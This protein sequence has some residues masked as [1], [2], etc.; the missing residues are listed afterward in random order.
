M[1]IA[2]LGATSQI[3]Q[4]LVR[5]FASQSEH[6]LTLYARRPEVVQN[7]LAQAGFAGRYATHSF[8]IFG[9]A[10]HFDAIL[11][12]VGAGDPSRVLAMQ[13]SVFDVT[14]KYDDMVL[15][16]IRS[17][18]GCR[19]IFL[20]SGAVYGEQFT[21]P[22]VAST[23]AVVPVNNL[24][25]QNWYGVV[26]LYAECR[27]R[28]LAPIPIV[29]I[30]VFNYFSPFYG[31]DKPFLITDILRAI[32]DGMVMKT[33]SEYIVRDYIHSSDLYRLVNAILIA[34][35]MNAA[36]DV[37]SKAPVDKPTLLAR[38]KEEFG[39]KYEITDDCVGVNATGIKHHYYSE[40]TY[41]PWLS[42]QPEFTSLEGILKDSK[43][44]LFIKNL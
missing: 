38:M 13:S 2:I 16:Y 11:N 42:Y 31:L 35:P 18:S 32:R 3:A 1:E 10:D 27:H 23:C 20:S 6:R 39:L 7:W 19:Y 25:S 8:D 9:Q 28:A 41:E 4:D 29:D 22:A 21:E 5:M 44:V 34:P 17:N 14:A 12:F 15:E 40:K 37:K 24:Q 36:I 26:K 30:R 33:S 43:I